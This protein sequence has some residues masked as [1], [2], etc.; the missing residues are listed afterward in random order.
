MGTQLSE[1]HG[2]LPPP[3]LFAGT[4]LRS[5]PLFGSGSRRKMPLRF[6]M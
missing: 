2:L 5:L 6:V 1:T 4:S 3:V